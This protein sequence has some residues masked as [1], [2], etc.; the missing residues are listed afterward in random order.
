MRSK[1]IKKV[2][3]DPKRAVDELVEG[4]VGYYHGSVKKIDGL[5]AIYK[6]DIRKDKVALVVGGGSGHEPLF[7][8]FVGGN[9][10]DGA[11]C[12]D[13]FAAPTPDNILAV[14]KQVN[15]GKGVLFLYG[16]Y[17]GDNMNFDIA[18]EFAKEEKI[19]V[20]TVRVWDDVASAPMDR[21]TDRRGIAGDLYMIK[22]AGAATETMDSLEEVV[23]VTKKASKNLRSMGVALSPGSIPETGLTTFTL[24]E[25]KIE[26]GMGIHGEQG[27]LRKSLPTADELTGIMLEKILEDL[28][29][30]SGDEVV[31]LINNLGATTMMECLIVNRK[32]Q[33]LLKQKNIKVHNTDIGSYIT[34]QE[35][36]GFSISLLKLD[37]ELKKLYDMPADSFGFN[38][39]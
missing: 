34:C 31:V 13:I 10:A 36:A 32:L 24:P 21:E 18:A 28:P 19:K 35:M 5:N 37:D 33:A 1:V 25:D 8:G 14:T 11:A 23:R 17:A 9:L 15:Q 2:I 7:H 12:G 20:E 22:I 16:N 26:I 4:L 3:N 38:K 30:R 39:R 27:V 6:T 29:Y